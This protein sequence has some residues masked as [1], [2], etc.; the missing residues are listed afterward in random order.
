MTRDEALEIAD[1]KLFSHH[2]KPDEYGWRCFT[3]RER[4]KLYLVAATIYCQATGNLWQPRRVDT[5]TQK[6][7]KGEV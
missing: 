1:Q 3:E 6:S 2:A 4:R 5:A 7:I